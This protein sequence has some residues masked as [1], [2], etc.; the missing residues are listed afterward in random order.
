MLLVDADAHEGAC[1]Q[2]E[3]E[4][5]AQVGPGT[6]FSGSPTWPLPEGAY[7]ARGMTQEEQ[8]EETIARLEA[9]LAALRGRQGDESLAVG[10]REAFVDVAAASTIA[11]PASHARLLTMIVETALRV[12]S[13]GAGALFLIDEDRQELYFEVALGGSAEAVKAIRVPLGHGVA[14]GVALSGMPLAVSNVEQ[15]PRWAADIGKQVGFTPKSLI[16]V[17]L[18]YEDRI[19]GVLELLDKEGAPSFGPEDI[20]V[21]NLFA[22]QAA[23]AIEQSRSQGSAAAVVAAVLS[24]L[25]ESGSDQRGLTA[26]LVRFGVALEENRVFR[27]SL[28]LAALVHE[29][30][31]EGEREFELC[32]A[33]LRGFAQYLR[34]RHSPAGAR[35]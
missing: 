10:L 27:R 1:E 31:R 13:A 24:S 8:P 26:E 3:R 4:P 34:T 16:C 5:A 19:I 33:L 6:V 23:I 14:G 21:L 17:P 18:F 2:V 28:D 9:E 7:L 20:E 12:I 11:A 30:V 22:N 32:E 35:T 25:A 15:D 29:I